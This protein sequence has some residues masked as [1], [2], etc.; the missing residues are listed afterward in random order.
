[1]IKYTD[2]NGDEV[3][4]E[5]YF[6]L[7]K[8]ELI[9]LEMGHDGGLSEALKRI[10]A[11]KDGNKI[12][13]EFKSLLLKAYGVRSEDGKRFIKSQAASEE[14]ASTEA[15]SELFTSIVTDP[16]YAA[17]FISSIMPQDLMKQV[18]LDIDGATPAPE[19]PYV[20][21]EEPKEITRAEAMEMDA[22]ALSAGLGSGALTIT[23]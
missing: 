10:V 23:D 15:Y 22:A 18:K 6:N 9:E 7:T 3:E 12:M 4:E 14:F 19:S 5:F 13:G 2:F 1:M 16:E 8:A 17:E 11:S 20:R 21:P